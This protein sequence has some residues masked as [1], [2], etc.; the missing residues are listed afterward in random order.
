M[1]KRIIIA[2]CRTFTGYEE[3][4]S[5]IYRDLESMKL[6]QP[7]IVLSGGCRGA[8]RLGERFAKEKGWKIEYYLPEWT[9]YGRAA[10]PVRNKKMIEQCD[11]V[12]CFW[13]GKSKGTGSLIRHAQKSNKQLFIHR[14][15]DGNRR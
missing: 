11:V 4:K 7:M 1:E 3:A 15:D 14:I 5:L 9:K 8:D 6:T 13:D 2:G 10:G 12:I